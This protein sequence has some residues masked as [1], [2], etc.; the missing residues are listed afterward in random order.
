VGQPGPSGKVK[1]GR[2]VRPP[3]IR[4]CYFVSVSENHE[5]INNKQT[6]EAWIADF[7]PGT[8]LAAVIYDDKS[9]SQTARHLL[10]EFVGNL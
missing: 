7:V 8:Q 4:H 3:C 9:N 2:Q 6:M 10:G 5:T 1:V